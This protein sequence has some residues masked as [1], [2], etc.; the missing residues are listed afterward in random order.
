[1]AAE[2]EGFEIR[3]AHA[4][5]VV[6]VDVVGEFDVLG[7]RRMTEVF[8]D[9]PDRFGALVVDLTGVTFLDSS[10]IRAL[11]LLARRC[12]SFELRNA[13]PPVLRVLLIAGLDQYLGEAA[14][15]GQSDSGAAPY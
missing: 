1:V 9:Q 14:D 15:P 10:G 3:V 12:D 2:P 7:E 5:S 8:A 13:Q 4:G 6:R 11:L